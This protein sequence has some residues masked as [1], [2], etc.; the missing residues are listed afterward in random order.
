MRKFDDGDI[1][2]QIMKWRKGLLTRVNNT[3]KMVNSTCFAKA[4]K[5]RTAKTVHLRCLTDNYLA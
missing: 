2:I 4:F 3:K 1:A 5:L